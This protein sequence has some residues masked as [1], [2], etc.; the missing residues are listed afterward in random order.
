MQASEQP[1]SGTM[2]ILQNKM[3]FIAVRNPG[4]KYNDDG[5]E[6][7]DGDADGDAVGGGF[8]YRRRGAGVDIDAIRETRQLD[9]D[10]EDR[11]LRDMY[12]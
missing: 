5:I 4:N 2:E 8:E 6:S 1:R 7:D 10:V 3:N 9:D 12:R 11:R